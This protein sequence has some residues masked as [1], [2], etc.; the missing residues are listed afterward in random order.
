MRTRFFLLG[1]L[2]GLL[3]APASGR[4]IWLQLRGTLAAMIDAVLRLAVPR[5]PAVGL[6]DAL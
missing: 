3:I 5:H 2:V 6:H 4:D 1:V